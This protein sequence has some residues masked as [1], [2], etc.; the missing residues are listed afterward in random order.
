MESTDVD[1]FGEV[2]FATDHDCAV[3]KFVFVFGD[4][5]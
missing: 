2:W 4:G 1:G 5:E 3:D